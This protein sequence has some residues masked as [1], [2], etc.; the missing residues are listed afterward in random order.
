MAWLRV[1]DTASTYP[2]LIECG[3]HPDADDDTVN[4]VFGW[5]IR[6]ASQAAQHPHASDFI[7]SIATARMI[8]GSRSALDRLIAFAEYGGI[9]SRIQVDG[10]AALRLVNNPKF[11]HMKT[12]EEIDWEQQ[13][14]ND[15]S[16]PHL[17]LRVRYRD[18]DACRYCQKVVFWADRRG[19][20]G[21][22]YDHRPPGVPGTWETSVVACGSCNST[23]GGIAKNT[24]G[25]PEDKL[26][27][28]DARLPLMPA[29]T[30]PY[31]SPSTR[32]QF[33]RHRRIL[34]Q[35]GLTPPPLADPD[36]QPLEPGTPAPG[37][38]PATLSGAGAEPATG[39]AP[40]SGER[41]SGRRGRGPARSRQIGGLQD[42]DP[43]GRDGSG[44]DVSGGVG[45]GA[46]G[47][48]RAGPGGAGQGA[49]RRRR[50]RRGGRR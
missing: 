7:V 47:R 3:E 25:S 33:H 49:R 4:L 32:A 18:G 45:P 35:Y 8:A 1:G 36:V 42:L 15:N 50:G 9:V 12:Q 2:A 6:V 5:F 43:P 11:I 44:R 34:A 22:T 21:G 48:G 40:D 26:A 20:K 27:A 23:R 13:Q 31:Y 37:A 28:A 14:R 24:P 10:R 19:A 16:D 38:A 29:P 39:D 17:T 30:E 46:D 41:R